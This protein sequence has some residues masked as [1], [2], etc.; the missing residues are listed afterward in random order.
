MASCMVDKLLR[1]SPAAK[2]SRGL[3]ILGGGAFLLPASL[4]RAFYVLFFPWLFAAFC[5]AIYLVVLAWLFSMQSPRASRF[6][7]ILFSCGRGWERA[8]NKAQATKQKK[9]RE[10]ERYIYA[11]TQ[12]A[13]KFGLIGL[14][15]S[16]CKEDGEATI[17]SICG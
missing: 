9:I 17:Y 6:A 3:L 4:L 10:L 1:S 11:Y 13:R 7:P 15:R 5:L 14:P 8:A 12:R 2:K 16:P